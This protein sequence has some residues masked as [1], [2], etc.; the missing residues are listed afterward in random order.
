MTRP[1]STR[2]TRPLES[3]LKSV[4]TRPG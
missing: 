4:T 3:M 2:L 1:T